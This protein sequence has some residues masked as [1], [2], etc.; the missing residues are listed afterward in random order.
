MNTPF[1]DFWSL[2]KLPPKAVSY[3]VWLLNPKGVSFKDK[4]WETKHWFD[5]FITTLSFF[6]FTSWMMQ[7]GIKLAGLWGLLNLNAPF[8][9]GSIRFSSAILPV[10]ICFIQGLKYF[11][12]AIYDTARDRSDRISDVIQGV[13]LMISAAILIALY[14]FKTIIETQYP[15]AGLF[16]DIFNNEIN[17]MAFFVEA[18]VD[19]KYL[20]TTPSEE[21]PSNSQKTAMERTIKWASLILNCIGK[22]CLIALYL[23]PQAQIGIFVVSCT[24]MYFNMAVKIYKQLNAPSQEP[25]IGMA[26]TEKNETNSVSDVPTE[27]LSKKESVSLT[28]SQNEP[29][30]PTPFEEK[31]LEVLSEKT[32]PDFV[33]IVEV[34]RPDLVASGDT[35]TRPRSDAATDPQHSVLQFNPKPESIPGRNEGTPIMVHS[36]GGKAIAKNMSPKNKLQ[37]NNDSQQQPTVSDDQNGHIQPPKLIEP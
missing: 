6:V 18:A 9:M 30:N 26:K 32:K 37:E 20:L 19:I 16:L 5:F 15:L 31:P 10:G 23:I 21:K 34:K 2:P 7:F 17:C 3:I 13:V 29:A 24:L 12:S 8:L 35:D 14:F 25:S 33:V 22:L 27:K 28:L 11:H 1:I 36:P 4:S